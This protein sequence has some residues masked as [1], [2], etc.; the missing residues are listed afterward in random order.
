VLLAEDLLLLLLDDE[1]GTT[2]SLWVDVKVPLGAAV[3]AELAIDDAVELEPTTSRWRTPK[4]RTTGEG[5]ADEV[6]AEGLR[7]IEEKP[8]TATD[9]A[10]RIG[11][12]LKDRLAE[13]LA[14]Q[15]LLE[16]QDDRV[17]GLFPRTRWPAAASTHEAQVR[18]RLRAAVVEGA[19]GDE[20]TVALAGILQALDR[21]AP[22][23]GIKGAEAR[24]VK[25]RVKALTAGELGSKAVRDAVEAAISAVT[26]TTITTTVVTTSGS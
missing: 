26:T 7:I 6:L 19:E 3:L 20:R 14:A 8:R 12:G 21:L 24:D 15:G 25:R 22:V 16:R 23:L 11:T 18:E 4:V 17:L 5:D 13:R 1:K 2:P 10:G 9:L